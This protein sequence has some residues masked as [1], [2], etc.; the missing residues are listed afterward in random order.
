MFVHS[1]RAPAAEGTFDGK[2]VL[3]RAVAKV[4]DEA[5]EWGVDAA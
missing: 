1:V 5:E 4:C 2:F 3:I